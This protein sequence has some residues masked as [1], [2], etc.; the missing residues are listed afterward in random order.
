MSKIRFVAT[1]SAAVALAAGVVAFGGTASAV[2]SGS[3][4]SSGGD[5]YYENCSAARAAGAA[6]LYRG[7]AGYR[8]GL[9]RDNDG[10]AC[11]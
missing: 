1:V 10:V 3:A 6:P 4:G 9:D 2:P 7:D 11:E 8:A 5:V